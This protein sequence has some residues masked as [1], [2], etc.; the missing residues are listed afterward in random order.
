MNFIK[1]NGGMLA[2]GA[3]AMMIVAGYVEL[4]V[5]ANLNERGLVAPAKITAMSDD[6]EDNSEDIGDFE[7]RW[8]TLI[9]AL[10]ASRVER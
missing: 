6:I 2:V 10:A 8:N 5:N 7:D 1:E 4:R 9:D 3:V